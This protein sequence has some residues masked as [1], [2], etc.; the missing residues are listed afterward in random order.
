MSDACPTG[1]SA[2]SSAFCSAL[3]AFLPEGPEALQAC[4]L[5]QGTKARLELRLEPAETHPGAPV[6]K[7]PERFVN[8]ILMN[9]GLTSVPR[10]G[11][12]GPKA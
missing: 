2:F 12:Q 9:R 8:K 5:S 11:K 6:F 4:F 10:Q 1:C 3:N 7:K